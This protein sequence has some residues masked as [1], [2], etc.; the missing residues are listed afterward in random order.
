MLR[1][2]YNP[3]YP[4]SVIMMKHAPYIATEKRV[5]AHETRKDERALSADGY[6]ATLR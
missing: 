5:T 4:Y 6:Q 1:A 3:A 2:I